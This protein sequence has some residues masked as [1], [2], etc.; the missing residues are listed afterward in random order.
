ME[1]TA[2]QH[3]KTTLQHKNN[4][5]SRWKQQH[6]NIETT[7]LQHLNIQHFNIETTSLQHGNNTEY[8]YI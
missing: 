2:L 7:V 6:F 1:I 8:F 3:E 4:S 5:T